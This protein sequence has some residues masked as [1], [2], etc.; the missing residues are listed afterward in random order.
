MHNLWPQPHLNH[1]YLHHF[2]PPP[3]LLTCTLALIPLLLLYLHHF[4]LLFS[5]A[6]SSSY[7]PVTQSCCHVVV[8]Q[9]GRISSLSCVVCVSMH[10]Y[11][12]LR[13]SSACLSVCARASEFGMHAYTFA[14]EYVICSRC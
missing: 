11:V 2:L 9:H 10:S 13:P 14:S 7:Q 8:I 12:C 5:F 1:I 3:F 6:L 4:L